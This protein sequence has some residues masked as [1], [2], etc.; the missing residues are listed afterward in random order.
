MTTRSR[1][2]ILSALTAALTAAILVFGVALTGATPASAAGGYT[3]PAIV[4]GAPVIPDVAA[5]YHGLLYVSGYSPDITMAYRLFSFDGSSFTLIDSQYSLVTNMSVVNDLLY[6][7]AKQ[8]GTWYLLT[9]D[10]T[11]ISRVGVESTLAPIDYVGFSDGVVA[12]VTVS[13]SENDLVYVASGT[14]NTIGLFDFANNLVVFDDYVYFTATPFG[15]TG[16]QLDRTDA[17]VVQE[18]VAP[19]GANLFAW[20]D[21]L[22]M[23]DIYNSWTFTKMLSDLTTE[24]GATPAVTDAF[25]FFD[26]GETMYFSGARDGNYSVFAYDGSTT[27]ALSGPTSIGTM[28]LFDGYLWASDV[29]SSPVACADNITVQCNY[30]Y[31][32]VYYFDGTQW[33]FVMQ[34][35]TSSGFMVTYQGRLYVQ[36]A[37]TWTYTERASLPNTGIEVAP[38][39][40]TALLALAAGGALTVIRRR[41]GRATTD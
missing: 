33:V 32:D 27:T 28:L 17:V 15:G 26:G 23:G 4:E 5:E 30:D 12:S 22:Y 36:N 41:N 31:V 9:Y 14:I 40:W 10:G 34:S 8:G 6:F 2:R 19:A 37:G 13:G 39:V 24:P 11:T 21:A 16:T 3:E 29:H 1:S 35:R 7:S 25:D 18:D 20:K 38:M